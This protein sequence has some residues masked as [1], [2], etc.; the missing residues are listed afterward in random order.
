MASNKYGLHFYLAV[1]LVILESFTHGSPISV[2]VNTAA[3]IQL[4]EA[5]DP[6]ANPCVDFFQY[7]C[8][9]WIKN[10]P[11]PAS[12]SGWS[13]FA[14]MYQKLTRELREILQGKNS[15]NDP[16]PLILARGMYADC[17]N[18]NAIET[19]GLTPLVDYLGKFGGWPMTLK[20][21]DESKF[22]WKNTTA[23]AL[24]TFNLH[25]LMSVF[26]DLDSN[27]TDASS[28]YVDQDSLYL[29]R[30]VLVNPADNPQI[31]TAYTTLI[32]ESAK[33][34][35]S[36]LKSDVTDAQIKA[37][38]DAVLKFE[39]QLAMITVPDEKRHNFTRIYNPMSLVELQKWTDS[40]PT[41]KSNSK[42]K[43]NWQEY[44]NK[45][46]SVV[47][48]AI[49]ATERVIVVETNY[50][51]QFVHLLDQ[52]PPRVLANYVHWRIVDALATYTNQQ[53]SDLQFAFAKVYEGVSQPPPRSFKCVNVVNDLLG[54]ALASVY[55]EKVMD[56]AAV[57]EVK[58]MVT[59]LKRAFK[60]MVIEDAWMDTE[61]KLT[62]NE[63]VDAMIEFVGY[64]Q[65]IKNKTALE[66][67]YDGIMNSSTG[68]HFNNIQQVNAYLS[69]NDL[70]VLR[71]NVGRTEWSDKPTTVNAF[72]SGLVNSISFPAAVLQPPYF[73]KG[74]SPAINYGAMGSMIGHEITHG[75]DDQG[76]QSD[77][78]GN[79]VQWWTE[80]TLEKYQERAKCFIDQYSNYVVL[81]GTRLN[82]VNTQSENIADNGG[83]RE[84]FRAYR[85][86]VAAHGGVD[87]SKFQNLTPEQVFFLA[88]ANSFCGTNTPEELGNLVESD[89]HSPHRF[90]VIGTL[91]NNEDFVREFKCGAGTP[92]NRLNKC[93]L[94]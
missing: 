74:I 17:M 87:S 72:Y 55:V 34:V 16:V 29:P 22:D 86:Y 54:F 77:K 11:I 24:T 19:L 13:Q 68:F 4:A 37:D 53:M 85:Y 14:I 23:S 9:G 27:N 1:G 92:M 44:L 48:I 15:P 28:I 76:R 84:A 26:N 62:A 39:S 47:D 38:A 79:T 64:P 41:G 49:P 67:Y 36:W 81:N 57:D 82:G 70:S 18:I 40:V 33:A 46:Y 51:K 90:R 35:R 78:N 32:V 59:N 5:M 42:A 91:S 3:A 66:E 30:S 50:L 65:W 61:T 71:D 10:N 7:A 83:V 21:W 58:E 80:K 45:I 60:S 94:W 75:F 31:T 52:T 63:K 69:Q 25:I 88:Y 2:D 89:P 73:T 12:K 93:V 6:T 43:I 20:H 8:G 56:D